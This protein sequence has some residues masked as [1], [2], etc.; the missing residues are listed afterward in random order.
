MAE[1]K[2]VVEEI[3]IRQTWEDDWFH[4]KFLLA[5]VLILGFVAHILI[6]SQGRNIDDK[7]WESVFSSA[8]CSTLALACVISLTIDMH[9]RTHIS[10]AAQAGLWI[11]HYVEKPFF[12]KKTEKELKGWETF[13]RTPCRGEKKCQGILTDARYRLTWPHLHI[14]TWLIYTIYMTLLFKVWRKS[15]ID[16]R[17]LLL[18]GFV[19]THIFLM[20]F[21]W[22]GHT[23]PSMFKSQTWL[24]SED[25]HSDWGGLQYVA[26]CFFLTAVNLIYLYWP[27]KKP[28]PSG[29]SQPKECL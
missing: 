28:K 22:I 21:S 10:A 4:N 7:I 15:D 27:P 26:L 18:F 8:T 12:E 3:R 9:M 29:G 16:N 6:P 11:T 1:H 23:F 17:R 5:G 24:F 20:V 25:Y 13:L 19:L 14:L 2:K